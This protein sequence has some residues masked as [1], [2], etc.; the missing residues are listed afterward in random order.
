MT[1][2]NKMIFPGEV[3]IYLDIKYNV[4]SDILVSGEDLTIP[5]LFYRVSNFL[6]ENPHIINILLNG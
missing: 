5:N 4:A 1:T 6:K 2:D 3:A